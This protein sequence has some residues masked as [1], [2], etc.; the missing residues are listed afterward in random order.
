MIFP[1]KK[2]EIDNFIGKT[3]VFGYF[4]EF[5][6]SNLF[7]HLDMHIYE[8]LSSTLVVDV[9]VEYHE[10]SDCYLDDSVPELKF[11]MQ[12]VV[13]SEED[14]VQS[15]MESGEFFLYQKNDELFSSHPNYVLGFN[16]LAVYNEIMHRVK[17]ELELAIKYREYP[18]AKW[19][20]D[21]L[22]KI[23]VDQ[24]KFFFENFAEYIV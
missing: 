4:I 7:Y 18:K 24:S 9:V 16:K 12:A 3:L 6:E 21:I 14:K 22:S 19:Y 15:T 13:D 17:N 20:F 1:I 5:P 10:Q 8:E 11:I 23:D 2:R